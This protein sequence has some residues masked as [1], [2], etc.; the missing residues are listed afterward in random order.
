VAVRRPQRQPNDGL[1]DELA[2]VHAKAQVE[3]AALHGIPRGDCLG[4]IGLSDWSLPGQRARMLSSPWVR[5]AWAV[6]WMPWL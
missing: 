6:P 4:E 3:R 2:V 1:T 5:K